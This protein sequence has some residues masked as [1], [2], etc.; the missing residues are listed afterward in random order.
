MYDGM[1]QMLRVSDRTLSLTRFDDFAIDITSIIDS[2]SSG[3][4]EGETRS[5]REV[6]TG[7]LLTGSRELARSVDASPR[8]ILHEAHL[9]ISQPLF[10][11]SAPLI[12]FATLLLGGFS[13]FGVWYQIFGAIGLVI[14]LYMSVNVMAEATLKMMP[15]GWPLI[16]LPQVGG[17]LVALLILWLAAN[18]QIWR[19]RTKA[20]PA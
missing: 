5:I 16:Y 19:R 6:M 18:P 7:E 12:G 17:L 20:V 15:W 1:A 13:R 11:I 14:G 4:G 8:Q 2:S 10:S 9:R 3:G